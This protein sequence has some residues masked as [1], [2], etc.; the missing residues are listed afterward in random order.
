M[1]FTG[2]EPVCYCINMGPVSTFMGDIVGMFL[3]TD[4]QQEC[5]RVQ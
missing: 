2:L 3:V 4:H 1:S 5:D